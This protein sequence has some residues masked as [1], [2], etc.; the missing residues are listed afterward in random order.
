MK[1]N[2]ELMSRENLLENGIVNVDDLTVRHYVS[3]N[4]LK[5]NLLCSLLS[6][7]KQSLKDSLFTAGVSNTT[8]KRLLRTSVKLID[9]ADKIGVDIDDTEYKELIYYYRSINLALIVLKNKYFNK[10]DEFIDYELNDDGKVVRKAATI[11]EIEKIMALK[12]LLNRDKNIDIDVEE[13]EDKS[14]DKPRVEIIINGGNSSIESIVDS[15]D[16]LKEETKDKAK[17]IIE[18]LKQKET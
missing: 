9:Y 3:K 8:Y 2:L 7:S 13:E 4:K 17:F 16:D 18:Q 12:G 10:M 14:S 5:L 1:E 6:D 15:Q 11:G